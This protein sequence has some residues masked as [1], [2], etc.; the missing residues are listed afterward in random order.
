MRLKILNQ[1]Y[2]S[3]DDRY[4]SIPDVADLLLV[5]DVTLT[6]VYPRRI[7]DPN[8]FAEPSNHD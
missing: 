3:T 6:G 5:K 7:P 4:F 8:K 2:T 1:V